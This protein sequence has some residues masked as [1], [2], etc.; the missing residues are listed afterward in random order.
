VALRG[1]SVA[2]SAESYHGR[3]A[4][5]VRLGCAATGSSGRLGGAAGERRSRRSLTARGVRWYLRGCP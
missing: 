1:T 3:A 4:R 5:V 2:P